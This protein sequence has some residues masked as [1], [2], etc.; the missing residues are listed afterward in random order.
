MILYFDTS[1]LVKLYIHEQHSDWTRQQT[2][3]ASACI[4]SQLA[5]VETCAAFGLKRRT[6]ELAPAEQRLALK[7]LTSEWAM[8]TRLAIDTSLL[9]EAG[10]LALKLGLRAYDSVQLASAYRAFQQVGTGMAFCC[11]DK[12]LNKAASD[13]GLAV[14]NPTG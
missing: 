12:Q 5:W 8:F 9:N 3:Q 7:R 11:F 6:Q 13:L 1:A 14:L 2:T 10:D 4:V